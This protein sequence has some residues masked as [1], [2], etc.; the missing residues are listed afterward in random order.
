MILNALIQIKTVFQIAKYN[1]FD[2]E[3]N[4]RRANILLRIAEMC[5]FV[6]ENFAFG[7]WKGSLV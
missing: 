5:I 2:Y 4:D 1:I 6:I 3:N 7:D